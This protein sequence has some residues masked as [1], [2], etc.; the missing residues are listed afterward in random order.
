MKGVMQIVIKVVCLLVG[1][2]SFAY[3]I[4]KK[5]EGVT[6]YVLMGV[7]AAATLFGGL[8]D[9]VIPQKKK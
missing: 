9:Q 8:F 1:I 6:K 5:A 4:Q 7:G 2:A 3:V